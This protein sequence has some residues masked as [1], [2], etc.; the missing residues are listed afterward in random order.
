MKPLATRH[1]LPATAGFH[2]LP[3]D[4]LEFL[5]FGLAR[6]PAGEAL[7][8]DTE[9]REALAVVIEAPE[10]VLIAAGGRE[11]WLP[12]RRSVFDDAPGAVYAPAQTSL[13]LR[14]PLLAGV[15]QTAASRSDGGVTH[16]ILPDEVETVE[17]GDGNFARR[18]S[19]IL[20][21]QRPAA[22][23]LAGETLNPPGNWSSSPPHKHDRQA[24]PEETRLEEIYLFRT[25]PQQGFGLQ[26]S[27]HSGGPSRTFA[28]G[29]LDV[30][31]IPAGYHPVVAAPG[32]ELYYLWCL[33][34][35]SRDLCWAPDPAH[36]WVDSPL[37]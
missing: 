1:S 20:P 7:E 28:V 37:R 6:V 11:L 25:R 17:R 8:L 32:Y 5:R 30:V 24:P 14:G 2:E 16:A 10:E 18:V 35:E 4:T 3:H 31:T 19:N 13:E 23:L 12:P 15:F 33:A 26:H 22:R 27:Y 34:G 21:R 29:D 36:A 9:D